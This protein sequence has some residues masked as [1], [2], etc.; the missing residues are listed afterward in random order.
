[1]E[2]TEYDIVIMG[3]G[4]AGCMSAILLSAEFRVL[5]VE[6]KKLPRNKSCSGV[7]I[8]KSIDLIKEYMGEIPDHVQCSPENTTGLSI[9]TS[10]DK[11]DF[12]DNGL[13][14]IREKFDYWLTQEA[15]NRGA[16]LL[17][18][19]NVLKINEGP[20]IKL[21]VSSEGKSREI[22]TRLLIASDGVNGCS[23]RLLGLEKQRKVI[24]YQKFYKA[25]MDIDPSRF[26]AF[27]S[28]RYS[29]YD[30]WINSKDG[31]LVIG[32]IAANKVEAQRYHS[33]FIDYLI[34]TKYLRITEEIKKEIWCLPLVIPGFHT[35]LNKRN[36]FFAGEVAGFLNP[37]G[38]GIS[39]ALSSSVALAKSCIRQKHDL[40][41]YE[42]ISDCYESLMRKELLYMK[43]QWNLLKNIVP[44]FWNN[45]I[46]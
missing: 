45:A 20:N 34:K 15:L 12:T 41:Q 8:K 25:T 9:I 31:M 21:T 46:H 13:N 33:V 22:V 1:V 7:L 39:I 10:S 16:S 32:V 14:I 23:R 2:R 3:A 4:P 36:I 38:E 35:V 6:R 29:K 11:F 18:Q 5:I 26:Y 17:E 40:S 30:A 24:T 19:T 27:T 28:P 44:E 42:F 43:G 37:F